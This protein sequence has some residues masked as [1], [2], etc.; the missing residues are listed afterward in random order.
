MIRHRLISTNRNEQGMVAIVVTMMVLVV[1]SLTTLGL[2]K[3]ARNEQR[4]ALDEQL[5]SEAFYAAE[6]GINDTVAAIRSKSYRGNNGAGS[7]TDP[8]NT[9]Q[10]NNTITNSAPGTG[11]KFEMLDSNSPSKNQ[12]IIDLLG[13]I[14]ANT[15]YTCLLVD[16]RPSTLEYGSLDTQR[17]TYAD[18]SFVTSAGAPASASKIVVGWQMPDG[19]SNFR[20]VGSKDFPPLTGWDVGASQT[21]PVL[22][23]DLTDL[24]HN[25]LSRDWLINNTLTT[26]L[27]PGAGPVNTPAPLTFSTEVNNPQKKG[28]ITSGNCNPANTN[29]KSPRYCNVIIDLGGGG[30]H[31][32]LRMLSVYHNSRVTVKAFDA[33]GNLLGIRGA[34]T[35]IDSTGKASDV[36]KRVQV[37]VDVQRTA[38]FSEYA[39]EAGDSICKRLLVWPSSGAPGDTGFDFDPTGASNPANPSCSPS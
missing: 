19:T 20:P 7:I 37:R 32:F 35:V 33:G 22:K 3:M 4:A 1:L 13:G 16:T 26:Y 38:N 34:Q 28:S 5:N 12:T 21:T 2:A 36:F 29:D 15:E 25:P 6:S 27:Y 31:Y 8:Q 11:Q 39:I 30:Q 17:S 23:I 14:S 18:L 9:C 10:H 24:N